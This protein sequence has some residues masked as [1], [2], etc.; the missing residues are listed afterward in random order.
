ME[1]VAGNEFLINN[2]KGGSMET[3]ETS[4]DLPLCII[5]IILSEAIDTMGLI[6][7]PH[8]T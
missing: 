6:K 7:Q 4:L 8:I 2:R 5:M 3:V 1:L